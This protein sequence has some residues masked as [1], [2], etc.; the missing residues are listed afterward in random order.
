VFNQKDT[1]EDKI[2]K[3]HR[4]TDFIWALW[5]W[6]RSNVL[7]RRVGVFKGS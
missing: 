4:S 1:S 2:W 5:R 6:H 3:K 7:W